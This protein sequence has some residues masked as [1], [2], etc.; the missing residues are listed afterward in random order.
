MIVW[1]KKILA[2]RLNNRIKSRKGR[3]NK[4]YRDAL[5]IGLLISLNSLGKYHES[6]KWKNELLG[7]GK[8]V[9][10]MYY[11]PSKAVYDMID[12]DMVF[13]WRSFD[14]KGTPMKASALERFTLEKFDYLFQLDNFMDDAVRTLLALSQSACRV[15]HS[16]VEPCFYDFI[17]SAERN[18]NSGQTIA[19]MFDYTKKVVTNG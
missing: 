8:R 5:K 9:D 14:W 13:D 1:K 15:G 3:G 18:T 11:C 12:E 7:E 19:Q 16:T 2:W 17:V 10:I 4:S 6:Q